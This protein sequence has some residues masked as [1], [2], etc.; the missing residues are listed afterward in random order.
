MLNVLLVTLA[1]S[2]GFH[3]VQAKR[4]V[5]AAL[6]LAAVSALI[7][8]VLYDMSA[9]EAAVIEL[10]VGARLTTVLFVFAIGVVSQSQHSAT[11]R[12]RNL[13]CVPMTS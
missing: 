13:P 1:V 4:L 2:C 12:T 9:R 10:G 6:G 11:P 8:I 3:A 7:A 5:A